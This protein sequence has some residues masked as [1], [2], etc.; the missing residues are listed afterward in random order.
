[1]A[2]LLASRWLLASW[3]LAIWLAPNSIQ[4]CLEYWLIQI[5]LSSVVNSVKSLGHDGSKA[6]LRHTTSRSRLLQSWLTFAKA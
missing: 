4:Y 5:K 1:M 2:G 3:L 6:K